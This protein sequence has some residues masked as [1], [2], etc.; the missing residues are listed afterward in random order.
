VLAIF[1][2]QC[3]FATDRCVAPGGKGGCFPTIG[4]AVAAAAPHDVIRVSKG[5]YHENVMI[6][7]PLSLLGDGWE[8][9]II[10]ATVLLNA[11]TVDGGHDSAHLDGVGHVNSA[12]SRRRTPMPKASW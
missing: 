8:N 4:A 12:G 6:T 3:L 11:I 10:D 2:C 7:K 5:T 9:T 1:S